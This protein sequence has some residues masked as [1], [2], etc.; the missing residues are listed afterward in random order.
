MHA[1]S[2]Q[3]MQWYLPMINAWNAMLAQSPNAIKNQHPGQEQTT[4]SHSRLAFPLSVIGKET[5]RNESLSPCPSPGRLP[6]ILK[7]PPS[8]LR[9]PTLLQRSNKLKH[10][11]ELLVSTRLRAAIVVEVVD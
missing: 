6:L 7:H 9:T 2:W 5:P 10:L 3:E 8:P 1:S 11:L 4:A